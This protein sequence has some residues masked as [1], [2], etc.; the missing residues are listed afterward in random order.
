MPRLR[1][2][3]RS[4]KHVMDLMEL[5]DPEQRVFTAQVQTDVNAR[6]NQL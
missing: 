4:L 3:M 6:M 2:L 5:R 1:T